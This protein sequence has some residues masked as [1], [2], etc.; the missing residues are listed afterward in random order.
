M[1]K[2]NKN[3]KNDIQSVKIFRKIKGF[4]Q[5]ERQVST[6]LWIFPYFSLIGA[7]VKPYID[8]D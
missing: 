6:L 1:I 7:I 5:F 3:Y 8:N 4:K 2:L